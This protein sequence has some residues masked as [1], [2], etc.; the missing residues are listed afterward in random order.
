[1]K[2]EVVNKIA[3]RYV[4]YGRFVVDL[5]ASMPLEV[6][7]FIFNS[8]SS[9]LKFIQMLKLIRLLRLGRM[10][11]FLKANQKLKFSMKIIQLI[12]FLMLVNHWINCVWYSTVSSDE[13][14]YP[15]KDLDAKDKF[16]Y[17]AEP[18]SR[19]VL[20]YYYAMV[21]LAGNEVL[22][23]DNTQVLVLTLMVFLG[24]IIIGLVIGEF[25]SLLASI[26]KKERQISEEIDIINTVML[27]LRIPENIQNRV[28]EY[29]DNLGESQ[30]IHKN[31]VYTL[32]SPPLVL[33]IKMFQVH[34][35]V[36][37]L[38]FLNTKDFRQIEYFCSNLEVK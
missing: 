31:E 33:V 28:L 35:S 13:T 22:P 26:T 6:F 9:N 8:Q 17:T 16:A 32:L 10:I 24:T 3:I 4:L 7:S 25:A 19:Y 23:A 21:I 12:F 30:F 1:M 11:T 2:L 20:F 36:N 29:Y 38:G 34:I 5:I 18:F 27:N 15:P 14:W 37:G